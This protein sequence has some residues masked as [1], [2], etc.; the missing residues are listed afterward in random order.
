MKIERP[1]IPQTEVLQWLHTNHP[2]LHAVAEI[3]RDWVWL[4]VDLRGEA[5]RLIREAIKAYGFIFNRKGGHPLPSGKQGTWGH[6][7]M[8]PLR[9]FKGKRKQNQPEETTVEVITDEQ[10]LA[11]WGN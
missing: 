3:D 2:D 11:E 7:C 5:N 6:S 1:R 10:I 4:P 8:R 9:F